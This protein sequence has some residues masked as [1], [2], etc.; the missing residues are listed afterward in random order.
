MS[1]EKCYQFS[2]SI[3]IYL[4][5]VCFSCFSAVTNKVNTLL[6]LLETNQI[7]EISVL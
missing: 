2:G 5:L 1:L 3:K 7:T 4:D 6:A